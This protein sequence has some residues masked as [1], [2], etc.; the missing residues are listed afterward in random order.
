[1]IPNLVLGGLGKTTTKTLQREVLKL[2]LKNP[3]V[4]AIT[5]VAGG[6]VV[7]ATLV[8]NNYRLGVKTPGGWEFV[9]SPT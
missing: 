1:M 4:A 3:T 9:C 6:V 5:V 2:A 8:K 7:V